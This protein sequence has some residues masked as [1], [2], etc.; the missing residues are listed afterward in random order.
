MSP[1]SSRGSRL[2][3][4]WSPSSA[5]ASRLTCLLLTL[6]AFALR[7]HALD[8]K[9][10]SYDEAAT[11]LMA[12][13]TPGEIIAFH[14]RAAFE[15]PPVWQL[16]MHGWSHLVGQS[17]FALRYLSVLAGTLLIPLLYQLARRLTARHTPLPSHHSP[18]AI[19][20]SL[21]ILTTLAPIL[22]YYSQEA[23]MY[24]LVV[25][26]AVAAI[27]ALLRQLDRTRAGSTVPAQRAVGG[28]GKPPPPIPTALQLRHLLV[29]GSARNGSLR[30]S[31]SRD[32]VAD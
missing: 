5:F 2:S 16:L 30:H 4:L 14:W 13:A 7:V 15:H 3:S 19:H 18:F 21:L 8:A 32:A 28:A 20:N 11:A 31:A 12:R 9:G 26:V 27:L 22:I 23:R 6:F 17:E 24:S 25:T 1:A 29:P 10:L